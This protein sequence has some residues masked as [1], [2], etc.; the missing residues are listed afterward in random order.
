MCCIVPS[1]YNVTTAYPFLSAVYQWLS[2]VPWLV[3]MSV[4]WEC[5]QSYAQHTL[6]RRHCLLICL[7]SFLYLASS[8][9]PIKCQHGV[10]TGKHRSRAHVPDNW[11]VIIHTSI[12]GNYK[13]IT[14]QLELV[15]KCTGI[16]HSS[17]KFW[18]KQTTVHKTGSVLIYSQPWLAWDEWLRLSHNIQLINISKSPTLKFSE[19]IR[20]TLATITA[21]LYISWQ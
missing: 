14:L 21:L 16:R 5:T 10:T 19:T 15:R 9:S 8:M 17:Y 13:Q 6:S 20:H 7:L 3:L 18:V 2:L 4:V 1:R 11:H 12:C